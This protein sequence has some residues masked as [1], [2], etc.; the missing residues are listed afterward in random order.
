VR[1][2]TEA[3]TDLLPGAREAAVITELTDPD[4]VPLTGAGLREFATTLGLLFLSVA[5]LARARRRTGELVVR[6]GDAQLPTDVAPFRAQACRSPVDGVEH[7]AFTLG[8]LVA[9]DGV[10]G[11][12][13]VRVHSECLPGDVFGS[14][15]CDRANQL[16]QG[17]QLIADEGAGV[18]VYLR[19][20]QGRGIGLGH[21]TRA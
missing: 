14:R 21:K 3:A 18:L 5:D 19:G 13:L 8:D 1:G 2:D 6:T 12:V 4:G 17:L 20:H 15:R 10:A 7:L 11:G 9:A 16:R